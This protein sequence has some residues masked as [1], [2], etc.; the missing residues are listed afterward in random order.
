V[1]WRYGGGYVA[2][3]PLGPVGVS[4]NYY[5]SPSLWIAVDGPRFHRPLSHRHFI[6]TRRVNVVFRST[7]EYRTHR[8]GPDVK[9]VSTVTRAPVRRVKVVGHAK[10]YRHD[11]PRVQ[12]TGRSNHRVVKERP[13]RAIDNHRVVK[14][15]PR[16]RVV[17]QPQQRRV[18]DD[19]RE[20]RVER[21]NEVKV[22][23]DRGNGNDRKRHRH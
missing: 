15:E 3:A 12:V 18:R 10:P 19:E 23:R 1:S 13:H 8:Q 11:R 17:T 6:P 21:K 7:R 22:K 4:V 5:S 9:Y 2:W 16:T 14:Q 20:V